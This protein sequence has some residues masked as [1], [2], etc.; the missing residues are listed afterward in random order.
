MQVDCLLWSMFYVYVS[1]CCCPLIRHSRTW[2]KSSE[3]SQD[4]AVFPMLVI[5]GSHADHDTQDCCLGSMLHCIWLLVCFR[6][7]SSQFLV[8]FSF[9]VFECPVLSVFWF[10]IVIMGGILWLYKT[11]GLFMIYVLVPYVTG[12][13]HSNLSWAAVHKKSTLSFYLS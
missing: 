5:R 11:Q 8:G 10:E 6:F 3:N 12:N 7:I 1:G 2:K 4:D 13:R 9:I